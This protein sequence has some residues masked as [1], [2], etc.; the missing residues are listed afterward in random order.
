M[1]PIKYKNIP[2]I[3]LESVVI[4]PNMNA[5]FPVYNSAAKDGVFYAEESKSLVIAY[6]MAKLYKRFEDN[7][8]SFHQEI[9]SSD[10]DGGVGVLCQLQQVV[11][12]TDDLTHV[13]VEALGR[14]IIEKSIFSSKSDSHMVL[15]N[16]VTVAIDDTQPDYDTIAKMRFTLDKYDEY[17]SLH[18]NTTASELFV[19]AEQAVFPG[20]LADYI[21]A[22]LQVN[23]KTKEDLLYTLDDLE[24]L[25]KVSKL[26]FDETII[27]EIRADI[28]KKTSIAISKNQRDYYLREQMKVIQEELGEKESALAD[29]DKFRELL[30]K[31][32]PPKE[33]ADALEKEITKLSRISLSSPE[34]N[35]SRNYIDTVLS[36]PFNE[37]SN[38]IFDLEFAKDILDKHH[39]GL[40]KVKERILEFLAVRS[41]APEKQSTI[42]CFVGPPGIGK[43]S[44]VK[45]IAESINRNYIR[46]SL[47]GVRDESDIRGHRK[48]YIGAMAGRIIASMKKA[49]TINPLILLDEIDKL[50]KSVSGDPA[51]ALLEV[52][53][54]EQN[55]AFHDH[56]IEVPYDLSNVLFICTANSLDTIPRPLLDRMEIIQLSSYTSLEKFHIAKNHLIKKQRSVHGILAKEL[57]FSNSAINDIIDF[58]TRE[59]GV[60]QLER[61]IS[62]IC[63]K[64]VVNIIEEG[65]NSLTVG[66]KNLE[67][68][69]GA[70]KYQKEQRN[71]KAEIGVVRGLAWTSVGGTTLSIEVNTMFGEGKF[72]FTGNVGKVMSESAE[73]A[74]SYIRSQSK[75]LNLPE[76]FYKTHDIHIHIP[77]GATPKDGPSAG[78]TMT[79]AILSAFT[80]AKIRSDVAMTG[81]ITIR[82][83]V[84]AIGGL[85][86]KVLAAKK[87]GINH[88]IIPFENEGDLLEIDESIRDGI[89]FTLAK[90]IEDVL[91]IALGEGEKIW[92]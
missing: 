47:G 27:A 30:K 48:T 40:E 6:P 84:L 31:K 60:R 86:E 25:D 1:S 33:I 19:D 74:L 15:C 87:I 55:N 50:G 82:G 79:T 46:L 59:A 7:P 75:R 66:S 24:R 56:Y 44:I 72:K 89:E 28:N 53:D 81:E 49:Q 9:N 37:T 32:N 42:L 20:E 36:L 23:M 62:K 3:P 43:T 57:K 63:R 67:D 83:N 21:S 73:V 90:T 68:L 8:S 41:Y 14:C 18:P 12:L 64:T 70:K 29:A 16:V 10:I 71:K 22:G 88:V 78:I 13:V 92:K 38:E 58:Y 26:V 51:S 91:P 39:Y 52:L 54:P 34:S 45:S 61:T 35:V 69:L 77:E 80:G 76:D 85:K 11:N 65:S 17:L 5:S 2:L 4:F